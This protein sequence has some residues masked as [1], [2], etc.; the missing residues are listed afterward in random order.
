[1]LSGDALFTQYQPI[2]DPRL[3]WAS[4]RV[5]WRQPQYW[6]S[7]WNVPASTFVK[8][9]T[10]TVP[11]IQSLVTSGVVNATTLAGSRSF[12]G[13]TGLF[14]PTPALAGWLASGS[15][16]GSGIVISEGVVS[17]ESGAPVIT[18]DSRSA[19]SGEN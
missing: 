5:H 11:A 12:N 10:D 9:F 15:V 7:A 4:G 14:I 13:M 6:P 2:W 1:M 17:S 19:T 18:C 8:S 3:T 16:L